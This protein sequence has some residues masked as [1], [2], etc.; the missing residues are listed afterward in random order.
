MSHLY[1]PYTRGPTCLKPAAGCITRDGFFSPS[2]EG[3]APLLLLLKTTCRSNPETVLASIAFCTCSAAMRAS[4]WA[5]SA[6]S[7]RESGRAS[8]GALTR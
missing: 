1:G 2:L 7:L 4:R 8:E 5:I 6:A 3:G